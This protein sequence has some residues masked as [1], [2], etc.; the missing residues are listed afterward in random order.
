MTVS[1]GGSNHRKS[2]LFPARDSAY[3]A[4]AE[5]YEPMHLVLTYEAIDNHC[6]IFLELARKLQQIATSRR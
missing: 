4:V 1:F 2:G 3:H 5:A 6:G